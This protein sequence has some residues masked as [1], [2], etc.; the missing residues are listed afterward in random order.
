M[1]AWAFNAEFLSNYTDLPR[2]MFTAIQDQCEGANEAIVECIKRTEGGVEGFVKEA[3][4]YD[5][6]GHFLSSYDGE[7]HEQLVDGQWIYMYRLN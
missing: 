4:E 1:S 3:I 5:G 6:R 2:E 7:E